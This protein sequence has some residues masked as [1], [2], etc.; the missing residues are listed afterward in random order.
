MHSLRRQGLR[1]HLLW[2]D[3]TQIVWTIVLLLLEMSVNGIV[4]RSC[5]QYIEKTMRKCINRTSV[6]VHQCFHHLILN[7]P[8]LGKIRDD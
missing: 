3:D 4:V 8:A 2:F 7:L 1:S 6:T 5:S